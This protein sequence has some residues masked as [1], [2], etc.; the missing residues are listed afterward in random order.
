MALLGAFQVAKRQAD[1]NAEPL[2]FS[3]E[4]ETFTVAD[5]VGLAPLAD[6][7]H[8]ATSGLETS[9]MEG[10][11]AMRSML[12]QVVIDEDSDR[13]WETI[14]R[15]RADG[16]DLMPI[17]QAVMEAQTG[18][19]TPKPSDSSAGPSSLG[20]SSKESSPFGPGVSPI[21]RD[22]RVLELQTVEQAGLSLVG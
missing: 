9:D 6:F 13:L 10:L 3:F 20:P 4:G 8:A 18:K 12:R 16:D 22:P 2:Q 17:I 7:A 14:T 15:S 19:D 21:Q 5:K 11:A 1:P